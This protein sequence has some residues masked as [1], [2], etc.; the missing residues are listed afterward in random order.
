M[1]VG[2][3]RSHREPAGAVPVPAAIA[4]ASA[5]WPHAEHAS[6]HPLV[7]MCPRSLGVWIT[8]VGGA[9]DGAAGR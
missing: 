2:R 3:P 9:A 1:D 6:E 7:P 4:S 5:V 8:L